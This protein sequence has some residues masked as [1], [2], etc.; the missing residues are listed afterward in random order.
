M[1]ANVR[2]DDERAR[3]SPMRGEVLFPAGSSQRA[4]RTPAPSASQEMQE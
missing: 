2:A 3:L 1:T 4:A